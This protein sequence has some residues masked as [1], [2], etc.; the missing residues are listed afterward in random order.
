MDDQSVGI[1]NRLPGNTF[2]TSGW[3]DLEPDALFSICNGGMDRSADQDQ[4]S[5]EC[6]YQTSHSASLDPRLS[7]AVTG[8]NRMEKFISRTTD[9][10]MI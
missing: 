8:V 7:M 4:Q 2:D 6:T 1:Y 3:A 10:V 9:C 5:H